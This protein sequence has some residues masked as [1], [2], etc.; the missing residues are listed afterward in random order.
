MYKFGP[1]KNMLHTEGSATAL[2][3]PAANMC[4]SNKIRFW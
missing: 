3:E 4:R 1:P 2:T